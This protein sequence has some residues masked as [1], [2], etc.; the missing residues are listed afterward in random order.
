L[1][2]KLNFDQAT[3]TALFH[4]NEFLAYFFPIIGAI[5][6]ES[7]FGIFKTLLAGSM[8]F[9]IGTAIVAIG[10]LEFLHLPVM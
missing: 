4:T 7:Y 8:L 1:Y 10:A 3:S 2:T 9:F 6:A 5:I